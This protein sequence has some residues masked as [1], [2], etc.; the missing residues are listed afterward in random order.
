VDPPIDLNKM[1]LQSRTSLSC[2]SSYTTKAVSY[3]YGVLE[4]VVDYDQDL[5]GL[6]CTLHIAFEGRVAKN[7]QTSLNFDAVSNNMA[8][9]ITHS[10][11]SF[12]QIQF[13]FG[14]LGYVVLGIFLLALPLKMAA[15]ELIVNCQ[16]V[17]LSRI[18]F[19]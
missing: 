18:F 17:Y 6:A 8:L 13:I 11:S 3:Q 2:P 5:E 7:Q 12:Q 15:V 14:I 4:L 19:S 1:D 16:L 10:L 9:V